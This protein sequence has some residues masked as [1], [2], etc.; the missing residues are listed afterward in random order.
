MWKT[1][2]TNGYVFKAKLVDY[3][4]VTR[5]IAL[6]DDQT[7]DD[8]HELL[9]AEFGWD[10]PHLYSFWLSGRFWDGVDTEYS[11]PLELEETGARSA[12]VA[13]RELGLAPGQ[14]IAYLFDYGDNWQVEVTVTDIRDASGETYPQVLERQGEAPPQYA[15]LDEDD[16]E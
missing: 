11:A 10:D 5:T 1:G 2:D 3:P 6:G 15:P 12:Q 8:L 14:R 9:R 13:L 7:L 16:A 4:S